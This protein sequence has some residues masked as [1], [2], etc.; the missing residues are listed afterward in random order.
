MTN[1]LAHDLKTP[2][3]VIG[4]YAENL[5]EMRKDSGNEKELQY[6]GSIMK[7]VAYTDDIIAKTLKLSETEQTKKLNKS[8]KIIR[9]VKSCVTSLRIRSV[10]L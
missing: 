5:L 1:N 8:R 4:G 9:R 7:N 6:L 2:L 10:R 3:A